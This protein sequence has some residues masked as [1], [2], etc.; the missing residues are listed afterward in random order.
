MEG[1][2]LS[3]QH[4]PKALS[5]HLYP[6][7]FTLLDSENT[8]QYNGPLRAIIDS[9]NRLEIP[10]AAVHL[11]PPN[12]YDRGRVLVDLY[13]HRRTAPS[14]STSHQASTSHAA[15]STNNTLN[16]SISSSAQSGSRGDIQ[17]QRVVLKPTATSLLNDV[18]QFGYEQSLAENT[19][20]TEEACVEFLAQTLPIVEEPLYLEPTIDVLCKINAQAYNANRIA[21]KQPRIREW[22]EEEDVST[23]KLENDRMMLMMSK[24]REF[25]PQYKQMSFIDEWRRKKHMADSEVLIELSDRP[26]NHSAGNNR[27]QLLHNTNRRI[28]RTLKFEKH[29][30]DKIIHTILNVYDMGSE[31]YEGVLRWGE[32]EGTSLGKMAET[33][34]FNIGNK[35]AV[36]YYVG[37]FRG[38]YGANH[39]LISD[40]AAE[41][42]VPAGSIDQQQ[43]IQQQLMMKHQQH[44]LA[45]SSAKTLHIPNGMSPPTAN[46]MTPK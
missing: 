35:V 23:K 13:D 12:T 38:F 7:Y 37:H 36:E 19:V 22:E 42:T 26:L 4:S 21:Q 27:N 18:S 5:L 45:N 24:D 31:Q 40:V 11:L 39:Q 33:I 20:W 16:N 25:F 3:Q 17:P 44:M 14:R 46:H 43:R 9:I 29:I 34:R 32:I 2:Q 8:Y 30:G 1:P 6:S 10:S 41:A 28:I 15:Q